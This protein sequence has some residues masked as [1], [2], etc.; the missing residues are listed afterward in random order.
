[1][2]HFQRNSR[3]FTAL[4]VFGA[5]SVY[6]TQL[7]INSRWRR[8]G[9]VSSLT[10]FLLVALSIQ[11]NLPPSSSEREP[12]DYVIDDI[13]RK[14]GQIIFYVSFWFLVISVAAIIIG[15]SDTFLFLA[16][17]FVFLGGFALARRLVSEIDRSLKENYP[18][19]VDIELGKGE[20]PIHFSLHIIRNALYAAILGS[21]GL[22]LA[23]VR[24]YIDLELLLTFRTPSLGSAI[25]VG[26]VAGFA[27]GGL[28]FAILGIAMILMH[29]MVISIRERGDEDKMSEYMQKLGFISHD[30]A[31]SSDT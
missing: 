6:F 31:K 18:D 14:P 29:Y 17:F 4:G 26:F 19:D 7:Q 10:I 5:I 20:L 21:G 11:R 2:N 27:A 23:W 9:I 28:V 24:G 16:Q 8:L 13:L 15:F 22:A 25:L 30:E 1:M 3:L 12:F